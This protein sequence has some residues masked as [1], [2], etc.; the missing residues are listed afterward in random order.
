MGAVWGI[1]IKG[2]VSMGCGRKETQEEGVKGGSVHES[3]GVCVAGK[4]K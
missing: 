1:A 2:S 3:G 4:G